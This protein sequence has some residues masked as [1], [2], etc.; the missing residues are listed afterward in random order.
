MNCEVK[1][2]VVTFTIISAINNPFVSL[3]IMSSLVLINVNSTL[4]IVIFT[5]FIKRNRL[6]FYEFET[7]YRIKISNKT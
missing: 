6:G 5:K 1:G 4:N 7:F 2:V 3:N